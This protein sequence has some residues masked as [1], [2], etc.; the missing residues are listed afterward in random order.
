MLKLCMAYSKQRYPRWLFTVSAVSILLGSL[1]APRVL[2]RELA[3]ALV[4]NDYLLSHTSN[5][6]FYAQYNLDPQ[7]VLSVREVVM[8]GRERT[9]P[10]EG[11]VLLLLPGGHGL[12]PAAFDLRHEQCSMMHYLAWAGWDTFTVDFEGHGLSTRPLVMETPVAFPQS[13]APIHSVVTVRNVERV[14]EF[15]HEK[16]S[17]RYPHR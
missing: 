8:A 16:N 1:M 9:V 14:V 13:S 10:K 4:T 3:G 11:K 7:V 5:E 12:G 15:I 2:A 17:T 6:P